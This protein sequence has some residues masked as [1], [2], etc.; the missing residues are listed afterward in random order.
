MSRAAQALGEIKV[1]LITKSVGDLETQS[2]FTMPRD[3]TLEPKLAGLAEEVRAD[4]TLLKG[5]EEKFPRAD[6][7][8]SG[9]IG[10]AHRKRKSTQIAAVDGEHVEGAELHLFIMPTGCS[11]LKSEIP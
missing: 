9:K 11:A 8:A 7:Q 1:A 6:E 5:A 3:K 10:F 2:A 4:F